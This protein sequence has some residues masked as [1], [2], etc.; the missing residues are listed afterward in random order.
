MTETLQEQVET[1]FIDGIDDLLAR[2]EADIVAPPNAELAIPLLPEGA[3]YL[4]DRRVRGRISGWWLST[5]VRTEQVTNAAAI[6][7]AFLRSHRGSTTAIA[8]Y[9]P[10]SKRIE[11]ES[12]SVYEL[13]MP[14]T[15]F[16]ARGRHVLRKLGF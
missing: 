8:A 11:T 3:S 7:G 15:V 6:I 9:D 2:M 10:V 16:A 5:S 12:G 4:G 14:D 1:N 13:G